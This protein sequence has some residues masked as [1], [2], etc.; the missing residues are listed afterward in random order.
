MFLGPTGV[1]KTELAK[2]LAEF[3]FNSEEAIV[4]VDMSELMEKHAVSKLIGSPPG[5]VG[6]DEGGQLTE[7]VRRRPYSVVLFDEIE[8]AHPE[9]FNILLQLLDDGRL[10]DAK[11]RV[12]NFKNTLIIM[13]SNIGSDMILQALN[14]RGDLGFQGTEIDQHQDI[15]SK[16][17]DRLKEFFNPEFLNRINEII[18][19]DALQ[20]EDIRQI[21]DLQ[22]NLVA[23]RLANHKDIKLTFTKAI[24][25]LLVEKGFDPQFGARP[26]KRLIQSKILDELALN[27]IEGKLKNKVSIDYDTGKQKVLIK[28]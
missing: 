17:K 10:S 21:V 23:K 25:D 24:K 28:G 1:G 22:L 3:M 18:V 14:R 2:A 8:K 6:Y 19:F 12:V 16:V 26:L 20:K 11:G 13:T 4:R 27:I 15:E 5:Y 7:K 9:V